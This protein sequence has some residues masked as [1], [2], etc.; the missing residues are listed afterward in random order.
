M[1][2]VNSKTYKLS[3]G[4]TITFK[5]R[6][7]VVLPNEEEKTAG[8]KPEIS[9]LG[10]GDG[11]TNEELIDVLVDRLEKLNLVVECRENVGAVHYLKKAKAKLE[12]RSFKRDLE[13]KTGTTEKHN[14]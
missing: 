10:E 8:L 12:E 9:D 6:F 2:S 1:Q 3:T 5:Q 13:E 7:A 14:S 4:E 11:V